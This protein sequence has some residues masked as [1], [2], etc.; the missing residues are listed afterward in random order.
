MHPVPV[1]LGRARYAIGAQQLPE[2][3]VRHADPRGKIAHGRRPRERNQ[4]AGRDAMI[5]PII[6]GPRSP[7]DP[8]TWLNFI[9]VMSTALFMSF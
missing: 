2:T 6:H 4:I 5:F 1:A 7:T 9:L 8:T 3:D